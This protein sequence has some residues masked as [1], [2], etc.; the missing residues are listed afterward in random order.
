MS[1]ISH[2]MLAMALTVVLAGT[3]RAQ[4]P[5][6]NS[7]PAEKAKSPALRVIPIWPGVA[8]GS[9]GWTRKEVTHRNEWD[10]NLIVRNVTTPTLTAFLP[11]PATATG[12]A[13]VVCPGGGFRVLSWDSEGTQVAEWLQKRGVAAFVLK[14]R[15]METPSSEEKFRKEMAAFM[16]RMAGRGDRPTARDAAKAEAPKAQEEVG[17]GSPR[18]IAEEMRTIGAMGIADGRQ[19]IK[20]VRRHAA[21]WGIKPD[22]VGILG[23]SAG[24]MVTMGVVADHDPESRP[25]FAAPIYGPGFGATKVPDDAPP[26]FILCAAD[27]PMAAT[28]SV[29]LYSEWRAAGRPAELHL[30]EKGGHGFGMT[31]KGLPVDR[32]IERFGDWLGQR[33]FIKA[34]SDSQATG[35][36]RSR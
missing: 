35:P 16:G 23:F 8:P 4:D 33:G 12:A 5:E 24:G 11:D 15:L 26:L 25:D 13:V 1:R 31:P 29:R 10:R 22:R 9:E 19:A 30:Y 18:G 17:E 27:D 7:A 34:G 36:V 3:G 32:W 21:E 28:G 2:V 6:A 14:Y 20:V